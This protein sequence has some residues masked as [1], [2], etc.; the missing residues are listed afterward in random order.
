MAISIIES[1]A[2]SLTNSASDQSFLD[3]EAFNLALEAMKEYKPSGEWVYDSDKVW[4][5]HCSVCG[6]PA[7]F[8]DYDADYVRS[9]YCP[10]CGAKMGQQQ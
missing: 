2:E 5:L 3:V 8:D 10:C 1:Y 9:S 7:F 4:I 6:K